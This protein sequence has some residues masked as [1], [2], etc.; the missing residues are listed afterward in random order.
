MLSY[1]AYY[2]DKQMLLIKNLN[3]ASNNTVLFQ[4]LSVIAGDLF[5]LLSLKR[6][7]QLYN[8]KEKDENRK[9]FILFAVLLN[10]GLIMVDHMHFQYNGFLFTFLI[11]SITDMQK[12][13]YLLSAFWFSILLNFKH[14]FLYIAPVYF[15]YLLRNY[16]FKRNTNLTGITAMLGVNI[17]DLSIANL[18]KLGVLVLSVFGLSLGPFIYMGQFNQLLSRLFPVKRGLCHA[19]WAANCWAIYNSLDKLAVIIG[20]R[21]GFSLKTEQVAS[22]TGGLVA[23]QKFAVLPNISPFFTAL[24]TVIAMLPALLKLWYRPYK[25]DLF[26]PSLTLCAFVSFVFGYHVHEKA[27]LMIIIPLT[28]L[29]VKTVAFARVFTI[30]SIIG[31]FALFPLLHEQ[32]ETPI[33][34]LIFLLFTLCSLASLYKIHGSSVSVIFGIP[35]VKWY[36]ALYLLGLS[37]LYLYTSLGHWLLDLQ[38]RLP[39]LPLLMTSLYCSIGVLWSWILFYRILWIEDNTDEKKTA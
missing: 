8:G 29:S 15:V 11:L 20:P 21:L 23:Q 31:H 4:R 2:F 6:Y 12:D 27:I 26:L 35:F 38:Q 10:A 14:I 13:N 32:A 16:C 34:I 3:Y 39:F 28:L 24:I 17:L 30:L 37:P 33:K 9:L 5:L 36:E 19:Y 25:R 1:V 7:V 22:L 18:V